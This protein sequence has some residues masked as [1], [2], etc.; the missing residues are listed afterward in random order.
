MHNPRALSL[1]PLNVRHKRMQLLQL[2]TSMKLPSLP[3]PV[4]PHSDMSHSIPCI[5]LVCYFTVC[6]FLFGSFDLPPFV[7]ARF[8]ALLVPGRSLLAPLLGNS[9]LGAA[10]FAILLFHS[11][12]CKNLRKL[13][14]RKSQREGGHSSACTV[15]IH[16][17]MTF[18]KVREH[19]GKDG[20]GVKLGA[21]SQLRLPLFWQTQ[22]TL[23]PSLRAA[24]AAFSAVQC[25]SKVAPALT[26]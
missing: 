5:P 9:G 25:R 16:I 2:C 19:T 10:S 12:A 22:Y 14:K 26:A 20:D 4:V 7:R 1:L 3:P 21:L 24:G 6:A 13:L 8:G 15:H 23:A 11:Q 17:G 18:Y